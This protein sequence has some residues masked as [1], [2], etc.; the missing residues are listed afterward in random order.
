VRLAATRAETV[1]APERP[2]KIKSFWKYTEARPGAVLD[3]SIYECSSREN[4]HE[5]LLSLLAQFQSPLLTRRDDVDIGDVV[6]AM[7]GYTIV[8][9]A[10]G[11]LV[12][13]LRNSGRD[14]VPVDNAAREF[15]TELVSKP[16]TQKSLARMAARPVIGRVKVGAK[17]IKVGVG[18]PLDI[19]ASDPLGADLATP[20]RARASAPLMEGAMPQTRPLMYKIFSPLAGQVYREED[21]LLYRADAPGT[22]D[23]TVYAVNA[24]RGASSN[25][26][27]LVAN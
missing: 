11:N 1:R 2:A 27:R 13:M 26:L 18:V 10:R 15:D 17:K 24:N 22:Q 6:F 19:E 9:F 8:I 7:P 21:R 23:V 20:L 3:F 25:T 16:D 4:A 12:Q 5:F 14:I